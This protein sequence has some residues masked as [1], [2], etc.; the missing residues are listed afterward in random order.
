M[1]TRHNPVC[2]LLLALAALVVLTGCQQ[3]MFSQP[4]YEPLEASTFFA[5]GQSARPAVA[6]AIAR[7]Q[8][9]VADARTTGLVNGEPATEFPF[10]LT[11]DV[12]AHGQQRYNIYCAPCHGYTGVGNGMVVQRGFPAPQT[13]H[14]DRLRL[15]PPGYIFQVI[16]TG[17]GRMPP[18]ASQI[19][20]PDDR[21]AIVAYVR[22]LQLS[23]AAPAD[24]LPGEDTQQL[25]GATP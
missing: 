13:L 23:Q 12:M 1:S 19:P 22:A 15:A 20:E 10:E 16:T 21:W 14:Q 11:E 6:G 9:R 2:P 4:R 8:L 24:Q 5:D 25:G 18:Y 7:G 17:F 3:A